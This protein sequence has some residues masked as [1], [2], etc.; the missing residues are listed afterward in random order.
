[1]LQVA[2]RW[3]FLLAELSEPLE[4]DGKIM[5]A[6]KLNDQAALPV[7]LNVAYA[8]YGTDHFGVSIYYSSMPFTLIIFFTHILTWPL[9]RIKLKT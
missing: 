4:L 2:A 1:M 6:A 8:G 5:A 3:D 9:Q 7:G